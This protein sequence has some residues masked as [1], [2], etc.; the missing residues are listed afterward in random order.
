MDPNSWEHTPLPA[1]PT[2]STKDAFHFQGGNSNI[3]AAIPRCRLSHSGTSY[4]LQT[5]VWWVSKCARLAGNHGQLT[6][7]TASTLLT[8]EQLHHRMK[9]T[10]V[11][12]LIQREAKS[13]SQHDPLTFSLSLSTQPREAEK[14]RVLEPW[15]ESTR[16]N[17]CYTAPWVITWF[18]QDTT[19]K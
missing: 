3:R 11:L 5:L 9:L 8:P 15:L 18:G 19:T 7:F 6:H 2:P 13:N 17:A 10:V 14:K 4:P 12:D 16:Q 1:R